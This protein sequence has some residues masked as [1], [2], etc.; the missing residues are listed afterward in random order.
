MVVKMLSML[1]KRLGVDA[2]ERGQ[3]CLSSLKD[4]F[5]ISSSLIIPEGC[6]KIGDR[7]FRDC[8]KLEEVIIPNSV[9]WIGNYAFVWCRNA[10]IILKKPRSEFRYIGDYAFENCRDV[11]KETRN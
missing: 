7:A 11:K 2:I 4:Y 10:V 9:E 3:F 1:K 8:Y 5:K 6:R